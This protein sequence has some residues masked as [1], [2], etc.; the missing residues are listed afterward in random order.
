MIDRWLLSPRFQVVDVL[1]DLKDGHHYELFSS[2]LVFL[3]SVKP[4]ERVIKKLISLQNFNDQLVS[5]ISVWWLDKFSDSVLNVLESFLNTAVTNMDDK[6]L[7]LLVQYIE[8]I[9]EA[10]DQD[11]KLYKQDGLWK[12]I[13][14]SWGFI[15]LSVKKTCPKVE[16]VIKDYREGEESSAAPSDQSEEEEEEEEEEVKPASRR[17]SK[18]RREVLDSDEE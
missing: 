5:P 3:K 16:Q 12:L 8:M 7:S 6:R 9:C 13:K 18:R 14:T 10:V 17:T 11:H 15:S 4:T 2:M 1:K